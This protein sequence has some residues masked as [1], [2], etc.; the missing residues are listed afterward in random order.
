M[1]GGFARKPSHIHLSLWSSFWGPL[2]FR[3]TD[4]DNSG[5]LLQREYV[6]IPEVAGDLSSF[7][8]WHV[9]R[10]QSVDRTSSFLSLLVIDK[11]QKEALDAS[12]LSGA[13]GEFFRR[14][15]F[16]EVLEKDGLVIIVAGEC[17]PGNQVQQ[18][19]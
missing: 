6:F 14:S 9:S 1:D 17:Q 12:N 8:G 7:M 16:N 15:P 3:F 4:V 2:H 13:L 19:G 10:I 5:V 11:Q 18:I